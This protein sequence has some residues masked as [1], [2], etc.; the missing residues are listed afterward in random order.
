[1]H[2]ALGDLHLNRLAN[3]RLIAVKMHESV[4]FGAPGQARFVG[5]GIAFHQNLK[6]IPV[7]CSVGC[8]SAGWGVSPSSSLLQAARVS[9]SAAVMNSLV[10]FIVFTLSLGC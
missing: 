2:V 7:V 10:V 5:F 4:A 1:M 3:Q 6:N 9:A 8:C